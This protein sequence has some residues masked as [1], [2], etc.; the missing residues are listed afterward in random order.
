MIRR[1]NRS[2]EVFDI[3][4]MAVVTKAM[5]AF[6]VLMLLLMPYYSS[7]PVGEQNAAQL[8]QTISEAQKELDLAVQKL[9]QA[10]PDPDEIAKLLDEA[11]RRLR[12]AQ[13][14]MARLKRDN[15]ALNGQVKRLEENLAE[16][17]KENEQLEKELAEQKQI[18]FTAQL[19]NWDCLDVRIDLTLL[20]R[21]DQYSTGD[22]ANKTIIK[23]PLNIETP[24]TGNMFTVI[25]DEVMAKF[26]DS[27]SEAPGEGSR[28]N[29]SSVYA[30]LN[31]SDLNLLVI[32]L[33]DK[34]A[35]KIEGRDGYALKKPSKNCNAVVVIQYIDP[36]SKKLVGYFTYKWQAAA[37]SYGR[38]LYEVSSKGSDVTLKSAL[39]DTTNKWWKD[40]IDRSAK[41]AEERKP[42]NDRLAL[43]KTVDAW[44]VPADIDACMLLATR[45]TRM[46]VD[47][48]VYNNN[49]R[50][51]IAAVVADCNAG[52]FAQA[53]QKI[54]AEMHRTLK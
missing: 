11:L 25:D 24:T 31:D 21:Q 8:A 28:F 47:S 13:A 3:S 32:L 4:L 53:L 29:T 22:G 48:N 39:S 12:E 42:A 9:A 1:P 14:L 54:K 49:D 2:I 36:N 7:G 50:T 10:K 16:A 15:D 37:D 26:P 34:K 51:G 52:R 44:T 41:V 33:R 40:Q 46:Q 27:K 30:R 45:A 17:K 20:P 19:I 18:I 35:S 5:G 6:L 43:L 23:Q 38:I